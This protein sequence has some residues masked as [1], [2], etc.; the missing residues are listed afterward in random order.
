[1]KYLNLLLPLFFFFFIYLGIQIVKINLFFIYL[2]QL[3]EYR[4]DRIKAHLKTLTGRRQLIGYFNLLKW[5]KFYSPKFTL[6][7]ILILIFTFIAQYNFF[8]FGLRFLFRSL[9]DISSLIP[10]LVLLVLFLINLITPL[11]VFFAAAISVLLT[12][13]IKKLTISLAKV[14]M[15]RRPHLLVIGITGSYGKTAVKEI[16]SFIL[17][18]FYQVLK[19]PLNCNTQLGVAKWILK[20]LKRKDEIFIV[21]MGAYKKG[22]IKKMAKMVKPKIGIITAVNEQHLALF[23]SIT[24][25]QW[26]KYELIKSLPEDGL[27]IFNA[28]NKY[29]K[30]LYQ[31]CKK[32]KKLY[33]QRGSRLQTKILGD[34]H[35]D[36]IQAALAVC[37]YLKIPRK[38]V[39]RQVKKLKEFPLGIQI[40]KGK[41]GAKIIDDAYSANPTGFLA[42]LELLRKTP[43]KQKIL[44]A[45]GIIELGNMSQKIH[46]QIGQKAGE[47]CDK[48]FLI[49]PDFYQAII[50]GANREK[51]FVDVE[52]D[53]ALLLAKIKG[54]LNKN[55]VVL[56]E[57]VPPYL[58]KK[59]T[60]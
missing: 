20:K 5:R 23:G 50:E 53:G 27:A 16:L 38:K 4:W 19:T 56:L 33:G 49:Q 31:V 59:L 3:K 45:Q 43:G 30:Y 51:T 9:E 32:P 44:V 46:R 6:R 40:K 13:P 18:N 58:G 15:K 21:E 36:N 22:E 57:G 48:V 29:T 35:R 26:A 47:F 10:L 39:Y 12:A 42:A 2:V 60:A 7:V 11:V 17:S 8:F 25:T 28:N 52:E 54:L 24:K 55:T 41:R 37:D 14:K 34:W 1:M